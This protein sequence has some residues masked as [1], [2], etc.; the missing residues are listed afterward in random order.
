MFRIYIFML[1]AMSCF[2]LPQLKAQSIDT[3]VSPNNNLLPNTTVVKYPAN[4]VVDV[5]YGVHMVVA[6]L[7]ERFSHA[8]DVGL[9]V[10]YMTPKGWMFSVSGDYL[11]AERIN[12]DV[13][14]NLRE[15]SGYIIDRQ[16]A[17]TF[18]KQHMRG[19]MIQ[20]GVSKFIPFV[21]NKKKRFGVELRL[22]GG[23]IQHWVR[24]KFGGEEL[25]QLM[26]DYKKG[27]DRKTSGFVTQ[28]YLGLRYM[29]TNRRYNF[30]AGVEVTE[31]FTRNRRAWNYDQMRADNDPKL[32]IM[33]G[34]RAGVSI[35]FPIYNYRKQ[36]LED[37]IYY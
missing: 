2:F 30:F 14:S 22:Q 36:T 9:K 32:D 37:V 18:V 4:I 13:L 10:N 27:Y 24:L 16:G 8:F 1:A 31:G 11:F 29:S 19:F 20:G 6:D 33:V 28:Q 15:Q 25:L 35:P 7:K 26:G 21:A 5:S 17:L 12:E 3:T 34:F 23:Y